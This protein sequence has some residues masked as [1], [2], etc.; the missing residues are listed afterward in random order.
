MIGYDYW[1]SDYMKFENIQ[2]AR[3]C[4][5]LCRFD[6]RC[7]RFSHLTLNDAHGTPANYDC[8]LIYDDLGVASTDLPGAVS[9]P[10]VC[11]KFSQ[12][13]EGTGL[14]NIPKN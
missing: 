5:E 10:K 2:T 9:G 6:S 3:E 13:S 1:T 12:E 8:Y 14:M 11:E 7:W 4:Q